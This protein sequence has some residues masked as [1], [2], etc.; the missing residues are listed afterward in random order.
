MGIFGSIVREHPPWS[1]TI[2]AAKFPKCSPIQGQL[3][4]DDHF[5]MDGLVL[6]HLRSKLLSAA[7]VLRRFW[8]IIEAQFPR[9]LLALTARLDGQHP[10]SSVCL[11]PPSAS[12]CQ[13]SVKVS[14]LKL[15]A[16]ERLS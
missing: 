7:W 3:V 5:R 8:T 2:A 4:R 11:T 14:A 9:R 16:V 15:T 6:E 10:R 13:D 12:R 1:M